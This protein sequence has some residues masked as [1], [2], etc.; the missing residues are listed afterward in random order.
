MALTVH[1]AAR[2]DLTRTCPPAEAGATAPSGGDVI[3]LAPTTTWGHDEEG[4]PSGVFRHDGP[5]HRF[6]L[7]APFACE[8]FLGGLIELT[9]P[10]AEGLWSALMGDGNCYEPSIDFRYLIRLLGRRVGVIGPEASARLAAEFTYWEKP[11][12]AFSATRDEPGRWLE[13][14]YDWKKA[15]EVAAHDGV[16]ALHRG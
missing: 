2:I 9:G 14:Y 12:V 5:S 13:T 15:F 16:V 7:D 10:S 3:H 11:A 6:R 1:A 4:L 8:D